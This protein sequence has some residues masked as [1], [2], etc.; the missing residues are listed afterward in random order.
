M[1]LWQG[2]LRLPELWLFLDFQ[3]PGVSQSQT[4][5]GNKC[6]WLAGNFWSHSIPPGMSLML[7]FCCDP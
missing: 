1:I 6:L 2:I 5:L 7:C 4:L 3:I